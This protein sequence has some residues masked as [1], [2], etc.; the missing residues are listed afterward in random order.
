MWWNSLLSNN[1]KVD[2]MKKKINKQYGEVAIFVVIFA[3]LLI[4]VVTVSFVSI[5]IKD[6]QQA[7]NTDLS[8][9]AYDSAQAGVEDAKRAI[10]KCISE[11]SKCDMSTASVINSPKCNVAIDTLGDVTNK[12][13]TPVTVGNSNMNQAYTCTTISLNTSDFLG[14]LAVNQS[15]II[16]LIG[17]S[18]FNKIQIQWFTNN[19]L[20]SSYNGQVSLPGS[21]V[22]TPLF[23]QNSWTANIP[24]IMRTQLIQF[25]SSFKLTDFD[26]TSNNQSNSNTLFLYPAQSGSN[27]TDFSLDGQ[28]NVNPGNPGSPMPI[29]CQSNFNFANYA[30]TATISLPNPIGAGNRTAFLRLTSLYNKTSYRV[31]LLNGVN[32]IQFNGVQPSIDSTGRAS[33]LYRRVQ[34]RVELTDIN[35]PYPDAAVDLTGNFCKD[36]MITD[37]SSDYSNKCTP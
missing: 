8:Q 19:D 2:I 21:S 25:G 27:S 1:R 30:C 16:P 20:G 6:Q 9:S 31:T 12:D 14:T 3:A 35:F 22:L 36:F 24:P 28:K 11:G 32:N 18:Q 33:D 34:A 5:M 13:G 26:A 29:S 10:L 7:S 4:T 15:K 17:T 37:S 23:A